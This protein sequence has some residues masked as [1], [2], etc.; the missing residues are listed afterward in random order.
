VSK[1]K[2]C[3]GCQVYAIILSEHDRYTCPFR[4]SQV[5]DKCP[6]INCLVKPICTDECQVY[7]D[8]HVIVTTPWIKSIWK[9]IVKL[10]FNMQRKRLM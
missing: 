10:I 8:T 7:K 6:C 9:R 4:I 2:G 3:K 5:Q 1:D